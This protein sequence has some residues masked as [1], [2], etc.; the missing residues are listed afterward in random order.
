VHGF[1]RKTVFGS[2]RAKVHRKLHPDFSLPPLP[3]RMQAASERHV[4]GGAQQV[5]QVSEVMD[6]VA[7]A[8]DQQ[9]QGIDQVNVAGEQLNQVTLQTAANA[10]EG[11]VNLSLTWPDFLDEDDFK[12]VPWTPVPSGG[13]QPWRLVVGS[14]LPEPAQ[15]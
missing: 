3:S 10:E 14:A 2:F 12:K 13:H 11:T 1:G 9:S 8:A 6:E 15:R 5:I 7:A 4:V